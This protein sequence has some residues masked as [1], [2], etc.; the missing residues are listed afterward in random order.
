[1][2][3]NCIKICNQLFLK[4]WV[5]T[6]FVKGVRNGFVCEGYFEGENVLFVLYVTKINVLLKSQHLVMKG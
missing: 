5:V 6:M 2:H 1:M 3:G 4:N